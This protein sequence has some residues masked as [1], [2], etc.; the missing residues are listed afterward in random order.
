MAVSQAMTDAINAASLGI[1]VKA[2]RSYADW[3]DTL[4]E[5]DE[6]HIDVVPVMHSDCELETRGEVKYTTL[7][8]IGVRKRF[9]PETQVNGKLPQEDLDSLVKLTEKLHE[10]FVMSRIDAYSAAWSS[11]DS[12]TSYVRKHLRELRQFTGIVRVGWRVN[13]VAGE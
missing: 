5:M 10:L 7:V 8:D 2:E 3:D 13:K 1:D 12:R 9:S 4:Q 11:T 6:L